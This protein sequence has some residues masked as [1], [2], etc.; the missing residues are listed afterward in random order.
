MQFLTFTALVF[1]L[2][3]A[4]FAIQNAAPVAVHFAVWGF[5]TSLVI[6]ILGSATLGALAI[7]S[8]AALAQVRLR[9]ALHRAHQRIDELETQLA[10]Q[11]EK[12]EQK[13][14]PESGTAGQLTAD[15][16]DGRFDSAFS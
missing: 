15:N 2:A 3:V 1:S 8:L 7:L 13:A 14:N 10:E 12:L 9:W 11:Q 16:D 4:V 6:V 5:E